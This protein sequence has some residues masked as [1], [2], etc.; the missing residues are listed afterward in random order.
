M[1]G[2]ADLPQLMGHI[3]SNPQHNM[4]QQPSS[5]NPG[6]ISSYANQPAT[7]PQPQQY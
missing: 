3:S 6:P 1:T 2:F 4:Q 5:H 7:M